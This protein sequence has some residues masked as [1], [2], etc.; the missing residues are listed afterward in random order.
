MGFKLL[1]A[2]SKSKKTVLGLLL[3]FY[4]LL[5]VPHLHAQSSLFWRDLFSVSFPTEDDGWIC[6][7]RGIIAR[8]SDGGE[9]WIRQDSGTSY[10]LA[11]I[12]FIDKKIG[13]AVGDAGTILHTKDGGTSWVAQKSPVTY[14][15]MGVH[16]VDAQHGWIATERA[17]I[18]ATLDGGKTWFVQFEDKKEDLVLPHYFILRRSKRLG[19]W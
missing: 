19:R 16:F 3:A 5:M 1:T 18:L 12:S 11:S 6:G 17:T 8:S 14:Y 15:L 10:T 9:K 4:S 13:W 7:R 2:S